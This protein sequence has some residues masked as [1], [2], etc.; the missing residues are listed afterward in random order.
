MYSISGVKGKYIK[1][2]CDVCTS[3]LSF[4]QPVSIPSSSIPL[5]SS[6]TA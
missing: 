6:Y 3:Y 5:I 4:E 2:K 1:Q